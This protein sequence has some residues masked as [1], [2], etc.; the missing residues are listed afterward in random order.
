MPFQIQ[1][2]L[3][4]HY[5]KALHEVPKC[6]PVNLDW[7][8]SASESI[9]LTT[10]QNAGRVNNIRSLFI[11]NSTNNG[12]I[13]VTVSGTSQAIS[14]G[15][16]YQGYFPLLVSDQA[17][18]VISTTG[19]L[20]SIVEF[21]NVDMPYGTWAATATPVIVANPLPVTDAVLDALVV[22]SRFNVRSIDAQATDVVHGGSITAGGTAQTATV[23]NV[24]RRGWL[25]Q[26]NDVNFPTEEL[27][28]SL[29]GTAAVGGPGSFA[30]SAYSAAGFPG[31]SAQGIGSGAISVLAASTGHTF[32]LTTW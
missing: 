10:L 3:P 31:G 2:P 15:A 13:L 26:N 12:S 20:T 18:F 14:L 6:V 23:S 8:T 32:A 9:D 7:T 21:I 1:Q 28:Y 17:K 4:I 29:T 19:S 22:S 11:D 5:S 16:G 25:L 27:W 30:L 24:N